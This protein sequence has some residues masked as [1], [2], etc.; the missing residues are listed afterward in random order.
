[1]PPVILNELLKYLDHYVVAPS[2]FF[3]WGNHEY[4]VIA[5]CY[6]NWPRTLKS[7]NGADGHIKRLHEFFVTFGVPEERTSD[8]GPQYTAGKNPAFLKSWGF[9]HRLSS[10]ANPHANCQVEVAVK[11][12]KRI[13]M[14]NTAGD[15]SIEIDK[16][17]R[18]MLVYRNSIDLK[19]R[20]SPAMIL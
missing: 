6:S 14:D 17:Q 10:V 20:V 2:D 8:G 7:E 1:M 12:V 4:V 9:H 18:A 19:T 16:F 11:S 15:C 5:D 3:T 13:T